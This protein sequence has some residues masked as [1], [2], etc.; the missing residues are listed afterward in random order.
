MIVEP[1]QESAASIAYREQMN[2]EGIPSEL[3]TTDYHFVPGTELEELSP[4]AI[5]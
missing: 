4:P 1:D 5:H 2:S 3:I